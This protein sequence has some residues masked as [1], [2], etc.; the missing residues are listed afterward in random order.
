MIASRPGPAVLSC[1]VGLSCWIVFAGCDGATTAPADG[2][3]R[4]QVTRIYSGVAVAGATVSINGRTITAG[5][6]GSFRFP[7]VVQG[8]TGVL[9]TAD[10]YRDLSVVVDVGAYQFLD[11]AMTPLDT[12]VSVS[13]LVRHRADGPLN[14]VLRIDDLVVASDSDG[15]W[16]LD[17][18]PIGPLSLH[19]D[20]PGYNPVTT[21]FVVH[22][23]GQLLDLVVT[24]DASV[25]WAIEHDSYIFTGTDSLN[26][27]RGGAELLVVSA[28]M[29]RTAVFSLEPPPFPHD[30]AEIVA[31]R[32]DLCG[33][34][35]GEPTDRVEPETIT[36]KLN[37]LDAPFGE[38]AIDFYVRPAIVP[39][40]QFEVRLDVL[41][42]NERPHQLFSVDIT[43]VYSASM[44]GTAGGA[45]FSSPSAGRS[46]AIVSSEND[47]VERR[48]HAF[49][50]YRF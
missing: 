46:V 6:D 33:F 30:W 43:G 8:D 32:L 48:P 47:L 11:L 40:G 5:A 36:M 27:N 37:A 14:A 29:G 39:A 34:L 22:T 18:V 16:R 49:Y 4:G 10:E 45:A 24:R 2:V 23:E 26:A 31:A 20:V 3:V 42:P 9:V 38:N 17:D 19:A 25:T 7:H 1:L 21:T 41:T 15:S 28:E 13:G 12:L 35:L 44:F 50:V